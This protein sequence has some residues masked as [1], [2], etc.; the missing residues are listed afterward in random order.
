MELI[1]KYI[2][3]LVF[4]I[5]VGGLFYPLLGLL[6]L[7]IMFL[8]MVVGVF[9]GRYWCG[10]MCPHGSLFDNLMNKITRKKGINNILKSKYFKW[11]FFV[12]FMG[13]FLV[14][15]LRVINFWGTA[16]FMNKLGFLFV[17]Q[18]LIMPTIVGISLAYIFSPRAWCVICP[19][20]TMGEIMYKLGELIRTNILGKKVEIIS[21]ELC[22]ECGA[23][24]R[25]CP[26]ELVPYKNFNELNQFTDDQCMK[27]GKCI[28]SCPLN[29]LRF[30]KQKLPY[31]GDKSLK[32]EKETS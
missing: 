31:S 13:M 26:L 14:R 4:L 17:L 18:Y 21:P 24:A 22:K 25:V 20:G 8:I 2:W 27:C 3:L 9:N 29:I 10:N 1:R 23:C 5:A 16:E 28:E 15:L 32:T 6:V 30:G 11:G 12:F 19:M 7:L